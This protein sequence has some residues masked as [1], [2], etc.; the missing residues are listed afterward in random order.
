MKIECLGPFE[1]IKYKHLQELNKT[2]A[3]CRNNKLQ[4]IYEDGMLF[5]TKKREDV[6]LAM[7]DH[8]RINKD[9]RKY[10]C[11]AEDVGR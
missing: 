9:L 3:T 2:L 1:G 7:H 8:A 11:N 5:L 6:K 10:G 4:Y